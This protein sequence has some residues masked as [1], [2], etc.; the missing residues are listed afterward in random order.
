MAPKRRNRCRAP[1]SPNRC[2]ELVET[3]KLME[4]THEYVP[5]MKDELQWLKDRWEKGFYIFVNQ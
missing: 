1:T 2:L 3:H 4:R 5:N